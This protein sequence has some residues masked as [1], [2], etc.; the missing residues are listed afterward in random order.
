MNPLRKLHRTISRQAR[1]QD[2]QTLD[3]SFQTMLHLIRNAAFLLRRCFQYRVWRDVI[4]E[5]LPQI[6]GKVCKTLVAQSLNRAHDRRGVNVVTFRHL[7][8][9]EKESLF[10]IVE[11]LSDQS[12]SGTTQR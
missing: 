1:P 11:N 5:M 12:T 6:R 8:R 4:D 10:V 3:V 2:T 7:T 9:R